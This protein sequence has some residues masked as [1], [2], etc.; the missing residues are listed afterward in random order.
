MHNSIHRHLHCCLT[1]V[2]LAAPLLFC[3]LFS[4]FSSPISCR[5]SVLVSTLPQDFGLNAAIVDSDEGIGS[6]MN[7]L[8]S[9][10]SSVHSQDGTSQAILYPESVDVY[11]SHF[12]I[13]LEISFFHGEVILAY[14]RHII[15]VRA[16]ERKPAFLR[17][18]FSVVWNTEDTAIQRIHSSNFE[19]SSNISQSHTLQPGLFKQYIL[20]PYLLT[21]SLGSL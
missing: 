13:M 4:Y 19:A 11:L 20:K 3:A 2:D 10:P 17:P 1:F 15:C 18:V 5:F 8:I 6:Q 12:H 7:R 14:L 21:T 9:S 16:V